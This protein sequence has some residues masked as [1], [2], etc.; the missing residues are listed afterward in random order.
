MNTTTYV[1]K[2]TEYLIRKCRSYFMTDLNF[3]TAKLKK[4]SGITPDIK[5]PTTLSEKIC[6]RLVYDHNNLYTM[7]ADKLAVRE[8][9][10]SRTTRVK[11]VPLIG[12]YRRFSHI[13]FS[14]LPDQF[15]LKCNHDSGSTIICT[16]KNQFN[17][18]QARKKLTLALK[19]NLYYTTREWQY[20]NI[21][22]VILCEPYVDLFNNA[23]RNSTPE[24]LRIHCFH[25]VAHYVEAD[26]TD[27][28][29]R[30][31]INVYDRHWNLQPFQMEY[32]NTPVAPGEPKL[33]REALLAAQELAKGLDYCRVDLML[34]SD[35]IYFSEITLSPK[36]G[37]LRITPLEWDTK[38]GDIWQLP[39]SAGRP[40]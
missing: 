23:D 32:P 8:Y 26:F 27:D 29:G 33:F 22:P 24:M 9:V 2:Y 10:A 6:H 11:V 17:Y 5:S 28:R 12:V 21:T 14:I 30:E 1:L 40:G 25:G 7:L 35:E 20:K 4:T 31:F 36:R 38:L 3:H 34:K 18:R 19:K 15:V 16:N 13:D 39:L 37:K